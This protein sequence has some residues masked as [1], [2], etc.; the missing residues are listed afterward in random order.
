MIYT[1]VVKA[2]INFSFYRTRRLLRLDCTRSLSKLFKVFKQLDRAC[3]VATRRAITSNV[4]GRCFRCPAGDRCHQ[5]QRKPN[6][7]FVGPCLRLMKLRTNWLSYSR[8][9]SGVIFRHSTMVTVYLTLPNNL[10]QVRGSSYPLLC[11]GII[12]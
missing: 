5:C 4:K 9:K 8:Y 6:W 10:S 2:F 12:N 1:R 7:R 3:Q 11:Y